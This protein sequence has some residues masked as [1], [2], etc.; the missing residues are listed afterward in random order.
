MSL[1][2]VAVLCA[3]LGEHLAPAP[4]FEAP[5]TE[6]TAV[7]VS[8]LADPTAYLN[9]GELLLTTGMTLPGSLIG[10][11]R[12]VAALR[13]TGVVA[14]GFGVGPSHD[15]VPEPLTEACRRQGLPLL[16]VPPPTPFLTITQTY[17]QAR[18]R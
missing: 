10:C 1:P 11:D 4:G 13:E 17:W 3:Q 15:R 2:T 16:L 6:I 9:G 8:E 7:H 12:Y 14:L 5:E 18:T